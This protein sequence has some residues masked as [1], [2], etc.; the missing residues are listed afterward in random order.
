[1]KVSY[2]ISKII[3]NKYFVTFYEGELVKE[4][5]GEVY[6]RTKIFERKEYNFNT[7]QEAI[8]ALNKELAIKGDPIKEQKN[9]SNGNTR[10]TN[11]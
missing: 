5:Q 3:D 11:L 7:R 2:K 9:E 1:M 8:I 6:K 4:N 10:I